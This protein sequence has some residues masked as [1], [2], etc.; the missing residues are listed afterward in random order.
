MKYMLLMQF[1]ERSADFAPL[2]EW[3]QDEVR[4]HIAFMRDTN[5]KLSDAGE[6]VTAEGLAGPEQ[7]RIVRAGGDG[8][9]VVTEGP[10]PETKE[11]LAGYWIVDCESDE[12]AV[13]LAAYVSTAPGPGG[14]PLNMPIEVRQV[15][16]GPPEEM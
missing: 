1:S 9:A 2:T 12:R 7:A 5:S 3:T 14:K 8:S 4:A 15:M 13:E 11:F 6:L 10:F 16:A